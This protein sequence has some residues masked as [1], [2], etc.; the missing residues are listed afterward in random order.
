[1]FDFYK[2]VTYHLQHTMN[3]LNVYISC[4]FACEHCPVYKLTI[5]WIMV[6]F[7]RKTFPRWAVQMIGKDQVSG[8]ICTPTSKITPK[9]Y[10]K[11]PQGKVHLTW[12]SIKCAELFKIMAVTTIPNSQ[13]GCRITTKKRN[14]SKKKTKQS[15]YEYKS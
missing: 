4:Q 9:I 1:M 11:I 2:L 12:I 3:P 14:F 6:Q 15:K 13:V 10:P 7:S 8:P 5:L